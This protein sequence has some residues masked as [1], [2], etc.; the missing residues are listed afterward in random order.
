MLPELGLAHIQIQ[1]WLPFTV[2][3]YLNGHD[4]LARQMDKFG[5]KYEQTDNCFTWI[6]NLEKGQALADQF[7]RIKWETVL[8][9][10]AKYVHPL[11]EEEFAHNYY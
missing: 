1:T 6:E 7:N 8:P 3:I 11:T 10:F 9:Q 5:K 2:Q 4:Y